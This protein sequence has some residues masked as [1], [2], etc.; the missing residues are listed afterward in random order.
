MLTFHCCGGKIQLTEQK[1][2]CRVRKDPALNNSV[3]FAPPRKQFAAHG[4]TK[5]NGFSWF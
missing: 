4:C 1:L 3:L 5:G 2:L